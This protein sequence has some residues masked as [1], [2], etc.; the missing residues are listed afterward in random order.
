MQHTAEKDTL[1]VIIRTM[2][3]N[4]VDGVGD[5]LFKAFNGVSLKHGHGERIHNKQAGR[6][7]AWSLFRYDYSELLVAEV[8]NRIAGICCLNPRGRF[9]SVGP[10]AVDPDFQ[11]QAVGGELM[12]VLLK[13]AEGLERLR[14][15]QEA[16][17][18]ASFS[19][20]YSC[21]F[22]PV[23]TVLELFLNGGIG[24]KTDGCSSN[25]SELSQKDLDDVFLYDN[26]RSKLDR[27]EDLL[28]FEAW[29][30]V[31]VYRNQ[32]QIHGFLACL[33]GSQFVQLGPLIA[34]GEEEAI[35]LFRHAAEVF[36]GRDCRT[37]VMAKDSLLVSALKGFGFKLQS[38]NILMVRGPWRP[39]DCV[40]VF[41]IFPDGA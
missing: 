13:R 16:F 18:R 37:R 32:G 21:D 30:S 12:K 40:E 26:H 11:G 17:N 27:R 9:G 31:F 8:G 22:K 36:K 6:V 23:A 25:V 10:V 7:W 2:N 41:G 3:R 20:Y 19:L 14:V 39:S 5:V 33:P 38:I 15:I 4:D 34:E 28:Y 35:C 29:G 24:R 1:R